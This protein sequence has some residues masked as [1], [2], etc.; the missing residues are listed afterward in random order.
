[1]KVYVIQSS[2]ATIEKKFEQV[3]Q[4]L[5]EEERKMMSNYRNRVRLYRATVLR[6]LLRVK[7]AGLIKWDDVLF[8][9]DQ[10]GKLQLF[11]Q[12][13]IH[14][15]VSHSNEWSVLAISDKPVGVDIEKERE[16]NVD[17]LSS[18]FTPQEREYI[19]E[20]KTESRRARF[21]EIWTLKESFIKACGLGMRIPLSSY[22]LREVAGKGILS[23]SLH[24]EEEEFW[25][26]HYRPLEDYHISIC[27]KGYSNPKPILLESI[28][29]LI[30]EANYIRRSEQNEQSH[31]DQGQDNQHFL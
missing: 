29:H 19:I 30:E 1:M 21:F 3:F 28:H 22:C 12:R 27:S 13:N 18:F 23:S 31:E 6:A 26:T 5:P 15:N 16:I 25:F 2:G 8:H 24:Q 14:F 17:E 4:I 7:L 11:H 9:K 10:Y 20:G